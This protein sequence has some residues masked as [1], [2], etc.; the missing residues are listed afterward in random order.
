MALGIFFGVASPLL[1]LAV[2]R[3]PAVDHRRRAFGMA[4]DYTAITIA[5]SCGGETM[6]P[7]F[8]LLMWDT[9]AHGFRY[10]PR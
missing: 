7:V 4:L 9:L 1:L 6:L 2:L 5:M 10:G 3:R 8:A